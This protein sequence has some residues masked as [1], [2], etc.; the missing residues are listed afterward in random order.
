[1]KF[2]LA[3]IV[4]L[5]V[6]A[7]ATVVDLNKRDTPLEVKLAKTGNSKVKA[8]VTNTGSISYKLLYKGTLL[9][10]APVDKLYVSSKQSK[11][12]L[13]GGVK[14][15]LATA[16][17]SED[18][19]LPIAAGQTMEFDID[20]AELYDVSQTGT[21]NVLASGAIPFA[22]TS[23]TDL[24]GKLSYSSNVLSIDV[25]GVEASKV[26]KLVTSKSVSKRSKYQGDCSSDRQSAIF[27]A[28]DNC[29]SLANSASSAALSGDASRFETFFKDTSSSVRNTV[30]ARLSAV[31]GDCSS[32]SGGATSTYCTDIY[33][34]CGGNV[35]AYTYPPTNEIV[36][37]DIFFDDLPGLTNQCYA[38]DQATTVLHEETHAPAVYSPGTEDNGYG[39]DAATSLSSSQAV[40]NA[41][42]YALFANS[43]YNNC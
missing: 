19:F 42:S 17:L 41:D 9:D 4:A 6:T 5:A 32:N 3:S 24:S 16:N 15:R 11:T 31:A 20:L 40:G 18:A 29:A 39:Y 7:S 35:L 2:T 36:Y 13:D 22:K 21:Y 10:N 23:S 12:P 33:S 26:S 1:M 14:L 38:Q 27:T 37:C 8:T 28:L 30:S 25:D 34:N 43:V